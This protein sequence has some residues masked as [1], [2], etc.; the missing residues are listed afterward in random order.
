M[1]I[2]LDNCSF[3]RPFD[4][5]AQLKVRI[6]TEAKLF[7]QEHIF[8]GKLELVWSYILEYE[9]NY[10]PYAERRE[11]ILEWKK[12]AVKNVLETEEVIKNAK[13]L[14][15]RGLKSEDSL[16]LACA[17][18]GDCNFFITTDFGILK[19]VSNFEHVSI[20]NPLQFI[21]ILEEIK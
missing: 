2:Y 3:N 21:E 19:K 5:Q 6:E 14:H 7:I 12:I 11:T 13:L 15:R 1:R 10:N 16:H 4:S 8:T 18:E 17:V 20:I 9:N